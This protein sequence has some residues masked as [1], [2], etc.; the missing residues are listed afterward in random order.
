QSYGLY[1]I[2]MST[3]H[4]FIEYWAVSF[5]YRTM[6]RIRSIP[7]SASLFINASLISLV[8]SSIGP[9][10]LG[11]ISS[12]GL[13]ATFWFDLAIY[14]YLHFQYNGWLFLFLIGLF[15][16]IIDS[17][18]MIVHQS[19]LQVGFKL[20]IICLLPNYFASILWVENHGLIVKW[21]AII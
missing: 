17:K 11:Y 2:I 13:K 9:F 20:Y 21:L 14:F 5:I 16:I 10:S 4:I 1:S 3:I 8:V 12:I 6:K 19:F 7:K 15:L 18:K